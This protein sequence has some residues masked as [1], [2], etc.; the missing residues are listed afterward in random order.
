[1]PWIGNS[2]CI[3]IGGIARDFLRWEARERENSTRTQEKYC[4]WQNAMAIAAH[5]RRALGPSPSRSRRPLPLRSRCAVPR[6]QGGVT[7]SIAVDKPSRRPSPSRSRHAI[8]CHRGAV[9]P[10]LAIKDP[11]TMS[12]GCPQIGRSCHQHPSL[13]TP[14]PGLS[15]GWLS[16]CLSS[17]RRLPYAGASH[18]GI[19]SRASHPAGCRLSL[20]LVLPPPICRRLH[21]SSH[22]Y[23][24]SRPSRASRLAG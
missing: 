8:H 10:S 6:H 23:L 21:L 9:T 17:C 2:C 20:L 13:V 22:R 7:P 14:L 19:A 1:M 18:C 5:C 4:I 15:S 24:L 12:M 3:T 11:L 16:R